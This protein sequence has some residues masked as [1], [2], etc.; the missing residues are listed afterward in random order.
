M[1]RTT[2]RYFFWTSSLKTNLRALSKTNYSTPTSLAAKSAIG[3]RCSSSS[4]WRSATCKRLRDSISTPSPKEDQQTLWL[5]PTSTLNLRIFRPRTSNLST[6]RTITIRLWT[7]TRNEYNPCLKKDNYSLFFLFK[8]LKKID[9]TSLILLQLSVI[10][11][12]YLLQRLL[13]FGN[14][15]LSKKTKLLLF[16]FKC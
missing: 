7:L 1:L 2:G 15:C 13:F 10:N 12:I 11:F 8:G 4:D 5:G 3:R 6:N 16:Y 9:S 14:T